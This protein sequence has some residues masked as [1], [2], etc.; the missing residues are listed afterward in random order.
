M[1]YFDILAMAAALVSMAGALMAKVCTARLI[2]R[3]QYQ[4][5]TISQSRHLVLGRLKKT[6]L[7]HCV[8]KR[9]RHL[10]QKKTKL[11]RRRV[12]VGKEIEK[13]RTEAKRR[14]R[15]GVAA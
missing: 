1:N 12:K 9:N 14:V 10:L 13:I 8:A 15:V 7:Q 2:Q 11:E 4:V 3:M 5:D 6:E